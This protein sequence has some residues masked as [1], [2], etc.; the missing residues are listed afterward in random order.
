[1]FETSNQ[2]IQASAITYPDGLDSRPWFRAGE[3]VVFVNMDE[4]VVRG[5]DHER[6]SWRTQHGLGWVR[7]ERRGELLYVSGRQVVLHIEH[8]Q[9]TT[10]VSG[11]VMA[12]RL[13]QK[14]VLG[15]RV[16]SALTANPYMIPAS[17][18]QDRKGRPYWLFF[19]GEGFVDPVEQYVRYLAWDEG[20]DRWVVRERRL[21]AYWGGFDPALMLDQ[22]LCS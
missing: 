20:T 15:F 6:T 7:V 1:M 17:W 4:A 10:P 14:H 19:W 22:P 16:L 2:L 8:D 12:R 3:H 9:E 5:E 11:F 13:Q 21:S 18:K